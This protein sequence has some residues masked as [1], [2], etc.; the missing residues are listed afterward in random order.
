LAIAEAKQLL[1]AFWNL[2]NL[3]GLEIT[4]INPLLAH[5]NSMAKMVVDILQHAI[6]D[7][8]DYV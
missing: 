6:G 7:I 5:K 3:C 2:P 1:K 8:A 4:E